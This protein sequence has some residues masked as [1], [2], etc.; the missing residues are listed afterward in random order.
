MN[1]KSHIGHGLVDLVLLLEN[2]IFNKV[3]QIIL[4]L[5]HQRVK[6]IALKVYV[7]NMIITRNDAEEITRFQE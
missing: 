6:V 3:I 2:T 4:F 7:D 1:W 5:K